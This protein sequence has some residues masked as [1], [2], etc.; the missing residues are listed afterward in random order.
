MPLPVATSMFQPVGGGELISTEADVQYYDQYSQ[1][2]RNFFLENQMSYH[3]EYI[4]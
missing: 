3:L 4:S 2:S 1:K